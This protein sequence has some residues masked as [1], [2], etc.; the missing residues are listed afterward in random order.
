MIWWAL[1]RLWKAPPWSI[2][3]EK[4]HGFPG[5]EQGSSDGILP[6]ERAGR[7]KAGEKTIKNFLHSIL[8]RIP[9][10][11]KK[12]LRLT[13][14]F[15]FCLAALLFTLGTAP[16]SY[17]AALTP[18]LPRSGGPCPMLQNTGV[19]YNANAYTVSHSN[20][21]GT[22]V[23]M[24]MFSFTGSN[25]PAI[26]AWTCGNSPEVFLSVRNFGASWYNVQITVNGVTT[27]TTPN[28]N[29]VYNVGDYKVLHLLV[30]A[31]Q[32]YTFQVQSCLSFWFWVSCSS[33]S[34]K[35]Q[36]AIAA[37]SYCLNGYVWREAAPFDHVC[38]TPAER[39]QAAYD[40]SQ[41]NSRV[42]PYG[43]YGPKSCVQGYVWREAFGGD[44]VCVTFGQR[45]QA[46]YDNSQALARIVAL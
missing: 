1:A 45:S 41:A 35:L 37:N 26:G 30:P 42:D 11:M 13:A 20:D 36:V 10:M 3:R 46:A 29:S 8:E 25:A 44:Y 12:F 39:S 38:V 31:D 33:W 21:Y 24:G 17:A 34:P 18:N 5:C 14:L 16:K 2:L 9:Q 43:A 19:S 27:Q 22:Q 28:S 7:N 15:S 4:D 32:Q 23:P 40:N 6:Q